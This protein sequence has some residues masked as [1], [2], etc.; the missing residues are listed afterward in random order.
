MSEQLPAPLD[1]DFGCSAASSWTRY[2]GH[3]ILSQHLQKQQQQEGPLLT[4]SDQ[5]LF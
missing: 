3:G 5:V 1:S 4:Y 2:V